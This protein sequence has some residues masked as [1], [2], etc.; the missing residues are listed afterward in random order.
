MM[1]KQHILLLNQ[2]DNLMLA[3]TKQKKLG[4][5]VDVMVAL[6][7]LTK[8]R[9]DFRRELIKATGLK[10]PDSSVFNHFLDTVADNVIGSNYV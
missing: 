10:T 7:N 9:N 3:L 6:R 4:I 1:I 5:D 2:L 8:A